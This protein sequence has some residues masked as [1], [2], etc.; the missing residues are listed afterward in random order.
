[1]VVIYTAPGCAGCR[2]A[3]QWLKDNNI[4]FV[5]KNIFKALLDEKEIKYLLSRCE[6]GTEDI[7]SVRSKAFQNLQKDLDDY[8]MSELIKLIQENPSILRRPL[9]LSENNLIIGYDDDEIPALIPSSAIR[10]FDEACNESCPYYHACGATRKEPARIDL[11]G[12]T[13]V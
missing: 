8:S 3:K 5:E 1:M 7:V 11:T 4:E 12:V 13:E 10:S 9:M 6:N 2:K